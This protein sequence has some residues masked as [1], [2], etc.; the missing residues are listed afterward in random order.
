MQS[1]I[2]LMPADA[3][4]ALKEQVEHR[5]GSRIRNFDVVPCGAGIVLRGQTRT[6]YAKQ[7][8]QHAV[9]ELANFP[10]L[11]NDIDVC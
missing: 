10:I 7:L 5:L 8:T 6:Y 9:M 2:I 1:R 3:L 4:H 11:A